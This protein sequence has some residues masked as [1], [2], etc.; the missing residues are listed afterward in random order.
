MNAKRREDLKE[1]RK[2]HELA[3]RLWGDKKRKED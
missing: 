3:I 1:A 2:N